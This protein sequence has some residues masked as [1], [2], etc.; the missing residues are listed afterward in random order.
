MTK[1]A[2]LARPHPFIV[3][4]MKSFFEYGGYIATKLEHL[5]E[6]DATRRA[7]TL[8]MGQRHFR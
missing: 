1:T 6:K 4:E 5:D 7:I 2:L 3:V 8:R